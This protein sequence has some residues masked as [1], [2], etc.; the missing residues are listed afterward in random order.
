MDN[1]REKSVLKVL[2]VV[3]VF[4]LVLIVVKYLHNMETWTLYDFSGMK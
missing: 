3:L 2:F 4:L 1:K